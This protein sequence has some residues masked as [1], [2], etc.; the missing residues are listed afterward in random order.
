MRRLT[1]AAAVLLLAGAAHADDLCGMPVRGE[2]ALWSRRGA[3]FLIG[4]SHGTNEIPRVLARL[5]CVAARHTAV[6]VALEI[7]HTSQPAFDAYLGSDGGDVARRALLADRFWSMPDGRASLAMLG[8]VEQL[9]LIA[10]T[11]RRLDVLAFNHDAMRGA[12]ETRDEK[13]AATLLAARL[14]HPDR[15][16]L[17]VAGGGHMRVAVG[18]VWDDDYRPMAW[19]LAHAIPVTSLRVTYM[20]GSAWG[21][22]APDDCGAHPVDQRASGRA[23]YLSLRPPR[24]PSGFSGTLH[25]GVPTASPPATRSYM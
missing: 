22:S 2:D 21:C 19:H 13:M 8:F 20:A 24:E 7:D 12:A 11:S 16:F 9:R 6:T 25:V 15:L 3:T 23:P 18:A 10:Q 17:V 1:L 14:A 4:E 5:A